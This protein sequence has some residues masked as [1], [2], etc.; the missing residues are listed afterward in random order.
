MT[1]TEQ[2]LQK[3]LIVAAV[4]LVLASSY[5]AARI[6]W[7]LVAPESTLPPS[8]SVATQ[9]GAT[10]QQ[11][12]SRQPV[13]NTR[14]IKQWA[15]FG[16]EPK[17]AAPKRENK[18]IKAPE[19]KLNLALMGVF[20]AENAENSTAIISEARGLG[21]AKRYNIGD[22]LPGNAT[23]EDVFADRI[24]LKR[25][26]RVETLRFVKD[27][28]KGISVAGD[29]SNP[30]NQASNKGTGGRSN[31]VRR[32][33]RGGKDRPDS[34]SS[35]PP[36][37]ALGKVPPNPEQLGAQSG[38]GGSAQNNPLFSGLQNQTEATI[39][40]LGLSAVDASEG[41]GY[42]ITNSAPRQLLNMLPVSVGDRILSVNGQTLGDP[43]QDQA[44]FQ[45]VL[46]QESIQVE[47]QK[48]STRLTV[49]ITL[50]DLIGGNR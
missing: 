30:R 36:V 5:A 40:Q 32:P 34:A 47:L 46:N 48:G 44:L 38:L 50:S 31:S 14:A 33:S 23:L 22:R 21:E 28:D 17:A 3:G 43:A 37:R 8:A 41:G 1:Q 12:A 45:Q 19:T 13:S 35:R 42:L 49:D 7:L 16:D 25:G 9:G 10:G 24:L 26:G 4:V 6:T 15:L 18:Q 27:S 39:K 29:A 2:W 11:R 20:V